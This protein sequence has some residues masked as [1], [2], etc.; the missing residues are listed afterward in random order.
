MG[1]PDPLAERYARK[2]RVARAALA[3]TQT[4]FGR[5][6][7]HGVTKK[8]VGQWEAGRNLPQGEQRIALQQIFEQIDAEDH[9]QRAAIGL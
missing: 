7:G 8:T 3:L 9:Q 1:K 5:L 6:V 2:V 4:E